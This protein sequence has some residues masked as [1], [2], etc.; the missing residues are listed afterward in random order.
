MPS[1]FFFFFILILTTTSKL[2]FKAGLRPQMSNL[3]FFFCLFD[4][5][6]LIPAKEG[7]SKRRSRR[8]TEGR[9]TSWEPS[10]YVILFYFIIIFLSSFFFYFNTF[11][12][13]PTSEKDVI[14]IES[15][16]SMFFSF[17]F[18]NF[19]SY[20]NIS[21]WSPII[22]KPSQRVESAQPS[23]NSGVRNATRHKLPVCICLYIYIYIFLWVQFF[24]ESE[25]SS[26]YVYFWSHYSVHANVGLWTNVWSSKSK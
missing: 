21:I 24:S 14:R 5:S 1:F 18:F 12:L 19:I 2:A 4:H 17:F 3:F 26:F 8:A 22:T 15:S 20:F 13:S 25:K 7:Q 23:S 10:K 9:D 16:Q 11:N 6:S